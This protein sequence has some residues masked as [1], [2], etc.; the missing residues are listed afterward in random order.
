MNT[1]WKLYKSKQIFEANNLKL[2]KIDE[3]KCHILKILVGLF[4]TPCFTLSAYVVWIDYTLGYF[5]FYRRILYVKMP[6]FKTIFLFDPVQIYFFF[7]L[8]K[9]IGRYYKYFID[10]F[11]T[12]YGLFL[13]ILHNRVFPFF[14]FF[15]NTKKI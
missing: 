12:I 9:I 11:F 7:W 4:I 13:S 10:L 3:R 15:N 6:S 14:L 1:R 2:Y 8:S 5:W